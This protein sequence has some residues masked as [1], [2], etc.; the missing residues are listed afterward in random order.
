MA[1]TRQMILGSMNFSSFQFNWKHANRG[2]GETVDVGGVLGA[3]GRSLSLAETPFSFFVDTGISMCVV[4][5]DTASQ[6]LF[7]W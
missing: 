4:H 2:M 7:A 1:L 6:W 5:V 3:L